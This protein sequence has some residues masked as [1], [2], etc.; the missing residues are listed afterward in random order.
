[1]SNNCSSTLTL[2]QHQKKTNTHIPISLSTTSLYVTCSCHISCRNKS[3][4]YVPYR[5][6]V[7]D[8][9]IAWYFLRVG[10]H[11]IATQYLHFDTSPHP[12]G[13]QTQRQYGALPTP[14][15]FPSFQLNT[16]T[17][18]IHVQQPTH[19]RTPKV[20]IPQISNRRNTQ[21]TLYPKTNNKISTAK[22]M[23]AS[24][25]QPKRTLPSH[26]KRPRLASQPTHG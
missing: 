6:S 5:P 12:A 23:S 3:L 21:I 19:T 13:F 9:T 25:N 7:A 10:V 20:A 26:A 17:N 15:A 18:F 1:M 4:N 16:A 24:C 14:Q 2:H 22:N 11:S 8:N